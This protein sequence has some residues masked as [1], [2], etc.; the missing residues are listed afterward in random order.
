M[1][2]RFTKGADQTRARGR[3][4]RRRVA[5]WATA[6]RA[7]PADE[8][9]Q[10]LTFTRHQQ[11]QRGLFAASPA[12]VADRHADLHAGRQRQRHGHGQR[13]A[14]RTTAAR[15][16]AASTPRRRRPSRS[17]STAVN[18]APSFTKGA[19]QTVLEDAGAADGRPA[20]RRPSRPAR[21]TS[22]PDADVPGHRQQQRR[23]V[24]GASPAVD[25]DRHADLHAGRQRQRHGDGHGRRCRTTAAPPT[26]ASIP[27]PRRPSRSRSPR[28]TTR[29][30]SPRAPTRRCSRTP[31][32]RR[33]PAGRRPS[34]AGPADEGGQTLTLHRHRQQQRRRC[35]RPARRS[36]PTGTLTYTPAANAN[37][38]ATVTVDLTTTAAPPTAASTPRR[39]RPSRSP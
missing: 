26:A 1:R 9:G 33:W 37:G 36:S 7:G 12:V 25:A 13:H 32:R 16:T 29:P 8:S 5:G 3:R 4:A 30:A 14:R 2:P 17:P 21:P 39:R 19:D 34:R 10:T 22:R 35:S 6:D 20:G 24:L 18:D 11:Q 15:P 27:R 31:G 38:S 28:S 23:A